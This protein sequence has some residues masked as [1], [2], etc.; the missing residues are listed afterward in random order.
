[1]KKGLSLFLSCLCASTVSVVA[2][3]VFEFQDGVSPTPDYDG[4]QDSYIIAW[5]DGDL[6][7][8]SAAAAQ[9]L[10]RHT[11]PE[12][13]DELGTNA[14][15]TEDPDNIYFENAQNMG[16]QTE[17][18]MGDNGGGANDSKSLLIEFDGLDSVIPPSR[19]GEVTS[20]ELILTFSRYRDGNDN[21]SHT[22]YVNRLLKPWLQ[23]EGDDFPDG[24]DTPDNSGGVTWNSTGI[25][26]WQAMGAEGPADVAPTESETFFDADVI[27]SLDPVSFD[28]TESARIWIADP[29]QNHG[30]KLSSEV[31]PDGVTRTFLEP[32]LT[33]PDGTVIYSSAP[34][35][36]PSVWV[37]GRYVYYTSEQ[38]FPDERPKLIITLGGSGTNVNN[39]SLY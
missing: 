4:T 30:V 23:G 15:G 35:A 13:P 26:L 31:Y 5:D 25:E 20:A 33:L 34:V 17:M 1:M 22:I 12:F 6:E 27:Q 19:A 37:N 11:N 9:Q 18:E 36:D 39:W 2:Q 38:D 16:A 7:G 10:F 29:S 8:G 28:V 32:D 24:V 3:D 14:G 21:P